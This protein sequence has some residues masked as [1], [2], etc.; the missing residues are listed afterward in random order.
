L[1]SI[2]LGQSLRSFPRLTPAHFASPGLC[3]AKPLFGLAKRRKQPERYVQWGLKLVENILVQIKNIDNVLKTVYN[4]LDHRG[5][6]IMSYTKMNIEIGKYLKENNLPWRGKSSDTKEETERRINA[7]NKGRNYIFNKWLKEKKYKELI[8]VV[9][10]GW[11]N[12][13][14]IFVPLAK[15]FIKEKE[16]D[17]L[18]YLCERTVRL[19]IENVLSSLK[20]IQEDYP[21]RKTFEIL[22][23]I[24]LFDFEE[25]KNGKA[26]NHIGELKRH[27]IEMLNKFD[28]YIVFLE[29]MNC[30]EYF[31]QIKELKNKSENLTIKSSDLKI[32]K[33]KL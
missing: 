1:A 9:H 14:A 15:Y 30:Y 23:E 6:K 33:I 16:L 7:Y 28:Q 8:S 12:E 2:R 19:K 11:F 25:Y 17:W 22:E 21:N 13:E 5:D 27:Y 18:K 29:Q 4:I 10:Q 32:I 31:E 24:N 3:C 20:F 26:F